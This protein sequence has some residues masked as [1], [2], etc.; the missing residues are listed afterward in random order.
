M[1]SANTNSTN[2]LSSHYKLASGVSTMEDSYRR[3]RLDI[4]IGNG[5]IRGE[6]WL[7]IEGRVGTADLVCK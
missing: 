3:P 4:V 1:N 2:H 5:S 6:V 7:V